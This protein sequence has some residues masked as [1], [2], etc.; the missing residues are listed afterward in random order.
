MTEQ[1]SFTFS[2][3]ARVAGSSDSIFATMSALAAQHGAANL[4]QG[5]PDEDGPQ[6]MLD[7]AAELVHTPGK[8]LN[9]YGPGRGLEGLRAAIAEDRQRRYG[10]HLDPATEIVVTV[11]ATEALAATILA[12]INPGDE[13]V[14]LEPTYDSYPAAVTM[15]GGTLRQV[16]LRREDATED[17]GEGQGWALDREALAAA[18]TDK[19]RALLINTPHN[20]TGTVLGREDLEFVADLVRGTKILV[21]TDEVYERLVFTGRHIPFATLPGMAERTITISSAAKTFNVTG[22]KIGW[23][24]GPAP[25]INA[26]FQA[27]QYLSFVGATPFQPAVA[28]ALENAGEWSD[29]WL[30]TLR[31]RKEQLESA[32]AELGMDILA[33]AGTYFLITDIT[34]AFP[35]ESAEKFCKRLPKDAGVV[36]IP[37]S[38]FMSPEH[39]DQVSTLVRW[40]FCKNQETLDTAVERLRAFART[41]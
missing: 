29:E 7:L 38:P 23:A 35:G 9:Q 8:T 37:V 18:I 34:P 27:K 13:L 32:F 17:Q 22:W 36:G 25:L 40:T 3:A 31:H 26:V 19:T 20:P 28:W 15:A 2:P 11:G 33:T 30:E 10:H 16:P 1:T 6:E 4:G 12:V 5:F 41:A 14:A 24:M 21:I 39:A